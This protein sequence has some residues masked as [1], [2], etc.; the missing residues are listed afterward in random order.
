[1]EPGSAGSA[2]GGQAFSVVGRKLRHPRSAILPTPWTA[3]HE[4]RDNQRPP[5]GSGGGPISGRCGYSLG[6]DEIPTCGA[7]VAPRT[8]PSHPLAVPESVRDLQSSWGSGV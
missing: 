7:Y 1:M 8:P 4:Y 3:R 6:S 5:Q 2:K